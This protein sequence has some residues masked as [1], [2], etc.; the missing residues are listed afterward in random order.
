MAH[1][2]F[3]QSTWLEW[4]IWLCAN[5]TSSQVGPQNDS[6]SQKD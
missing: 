4:P 1:V 2:T 5:G 3:D 6:P